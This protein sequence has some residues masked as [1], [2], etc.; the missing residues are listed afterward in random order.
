MHGVFVGIIL[1]INLL[2]IAKCVLGLSS[3]FS[4]LSSEIEF[5]YSEELSLRRCAAY[6]TAKKNIL[7]AA[8]YFK[9]SSDY[10]LKII[11]K[12]DNN[13]Q[14]C[15]NSALGLKAI[16]HNQNID[17]YK[18]EMPNWVYSFGDF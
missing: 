5:Y 6:I 13:Y 12:Q 3:E 14:S 2:F 9:K 1:S 15:N 18:Y 8:K 16:F 4:K 10:F 11:S 17:A 7:S